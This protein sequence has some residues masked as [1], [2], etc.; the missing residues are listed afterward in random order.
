MQPTFFKKIWW[1]V[2]LEYETKQCMQ[3]HA[4]FLVFQW[5]ISCQ[6]VTILCSAL[7]VRV[8]RTMVKD[9]TLNLQKNKGTGVQPCSQACDRKYIW[10]IYPKVYEVQKDVILGK[11]QRKEKQYIPDV[12]RHRICGAYALFPPWKDQSVHRSGGCKGPVA[13]TIKNI[14]IS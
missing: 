9:Q 3:K 5:Y 7:H 13:G 8:P 1:L 4:P 10:T 11:L 2:K 14:E 12:C 6:D